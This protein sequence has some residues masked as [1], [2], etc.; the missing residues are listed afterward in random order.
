MFLKRLQ[1]D[2]RFRVPD[3]WK[4]SLLDDLAK[5]GTGHTPDKR[6]PEYYG[7]G[8]KWVSLKDSDKLDRRWISDTE[9]E[10][11]EAGIANSSAVLH[12]PGVVIVSRDAGVG[13]SAITTEP[14]AVSQ[15]FVVWNCGPH[16]DNTFLYYWLQLTKKEFERVAVGSTIKTIGLPYFR[17]LDILQPPIP[18]QQK[19]AAILSTWDRA[20]ELTEKLI[21]AKQ[22]RKQALM[23]QLLTGKVRFKEFEGRSWKWVELGKLTKSVKRPIS[24]DD[25]QLYKLASIRRH[26]K[27]MFFREPAYGHQI[28]VKKLFTIEQNDF[29]IS[30]IQAAYGAMGLVPKK[31]HNTY[32]SD[33]YTV[34]I[35]KN[36]DAFDISFLGFISET[37]W[38]RHQ[39]LL[40][41]NGFFAERLRLL[42]SASELLKR[43]VFV[44]PSIEEQRRIVEVLRTAVRELKYDQS[45]LKYLKE[46]KKGLMQQLLTG[47]VRV[48]VDANTVNG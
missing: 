37:S 47:K 38:F 36:E 21:A 1:Q 20:I 16:L 46:Q 27:G 41:C 10:I 31:F 4:I 17:K 13:K 34:L 19:I 9:D 5:R 30:N 40:A 8:I 25:E 11:S 14:M 29:L 48:N 6:F 26:S 23:Q 3:G 15:H 7:G 42:F 43:K 33:Q 12:P 22:K 18:E 28:K 44:P 45:R 2:G 39:I 35:A 24:W 32:I